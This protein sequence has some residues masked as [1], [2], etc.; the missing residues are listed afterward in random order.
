MTNV[1]HN[2]NEKTNVL[3]NVQKHKEK[4]LQESDGF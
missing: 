3:V 4:Q 2:T 1:T